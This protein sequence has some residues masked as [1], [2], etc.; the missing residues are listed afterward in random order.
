MRL[1][2]RAKPPSAGSV[3]RKRANLATRRPL[4]MRAGSNKPLLIGIVALV[5]AVGVLVIQ[6]SYAFDCAVTDK[7]VNQ[8]RPWIGAA[9]NK[10]PDAP[11]GS[12]A[13]V[14]IAWHE[15]RIG[16]KVDIV[17]TYHPIGQN[18]L[19]ADD[20]YFATRANTI[21]FANWKPGS[22]WGSVAG[23]ANDAGIIQMASSIRSLGSTKIFLTLHHEPENDVSGGSTSCPAG[24]AY[25]G[26]AGTPAQYRAMWAHVRQVFDNQ[27]VTNVVWV[28]DYMN[29]PP[30]DCLVAD[31]YPGSNLVDWVMFNAYGSGSAPNFQANVSRFLQLL[32]TDQARNP[33]LDFNSKPM[34]IVEW[35][36]H[37]ATGPQ[38]YAY[39]DQAKQA[40]ESNMF[41]QLRAYMIFD[42]VG[43][44][45]NENRIDYVNPG[46]KDDTKQQHYAAFAQSLA[47]NGTGLVPVIGAPV[48]NPFANPPRTI[49]VALPILSGGSQGSCPA[50]QYEVTN[51]P[52]K[53]GAVVIYLTLTLKLLNGAVGLVIMLLLVIA[54]VQYIISLGNPERT[55]AAQKR[56]KHTI[57]A[58][59]IY[60]AMFAIL[61]FLVPGGLL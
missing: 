14:Q 42:S 58:L 33:A 18:S 41:P 20:K 23:G 22:N 9:A 56:L 1:L 61:S 51:D 52:A 35:D 27:G 8:C 39:F 29:Y 38:E 40:V 48:P 13:Q 47:F 5:V 21:L 50:G 59:V 55:N 43:P 6:H 37:N 26:G 16:R 11:G 3:S 34:G 57:I 10:Y 28:I 46:V 19:T 49:C 24:F 12:G 53:G 7:L 60:L 25:R 36:I 17:H 54:G 15:T 32:S 44:D 4:L 30:W 45:G 31:L 2:S